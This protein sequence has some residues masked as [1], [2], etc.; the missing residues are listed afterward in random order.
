MAIRTRGTPRTPNFARPRYP[1][2]VVQTTGTKNLLDST[3]RINLIS[4]VME[5][6]QRIQLQRKLLKYADQRPDGCWIWKKKTRKNGYGQITYMWKG[7]RKHTSPHRLAY[8]I[9]RSRFDLIENPQLFVCHKC[10]NKDCISPHHMFVGD[11]LDNAMDDVL[12]NPNVSREFSLKITALYQKK[13]NIRPC[14]LR[15]HLQSLE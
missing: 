1:R 11:W 2:G 14:N 8:I 13:Y 15:R 12:R 6:K 3:R 7:Y 9:F 4:T 5:T 10:D